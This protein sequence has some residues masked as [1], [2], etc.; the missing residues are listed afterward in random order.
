MSPETGDGLWLL[1]SA[2]LG[3]SEPGLQ[4]TGNTLL[5]SNREEIV[6]IIRS[7]LA[8]NSVSHKIRVIGSGHSWS[9][10][11]VSDNLQLSLEKYKVCEGVFFL[12]CDLGLLVQGLV[13]IDHAL[14]QVTVRA[15]T[16][17]HELNT[18]LDDNGLAM[19]ILG[20]VSDQTVAGAISTGK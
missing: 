20:S 15:G 14:K 10:I 13:S 12:R 8:N 19:S 7:A 2:L 18:I 6:H 11:A 3:Y 1:P 17:F 9:K 4:H 5:P 16:T